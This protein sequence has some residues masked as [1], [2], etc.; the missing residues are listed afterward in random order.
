MGVMRFLLHPTELIADLPEAHRACI[1]GL[2]GRIFPTRV[3]IDGNIM[4]CRRQSSDSGKLHVAW[5]VEGFGRPVITSSS[6]PERDEPYVLA[7]ELARGKIC[8][9]RD[10]IGYW[11]LA[12]M[13]VPDEFLGLHREA[14]RQFARATA[15]QDQPE[16][17]TRLANSALAYAFQ[18]AEIV[19]KSYTNQRL[20]VRR[21][22]TTHLPASLGCNLGHTVP[23]SSWADQFCE[24]FTAA[25]VPL[26]WR[27]IEPK[28]GEY[29]WDVYDQQ[30]EWCQQNNLLVIGG[31]LIDLSPEGI[32]GWLRQWEHDFFNLQSFVCD[33]IETAMS[34]YVGKVRNWEIASRVN[35][36]GYLALNEE[37]RLTLAARTL[38]IASQV[39]DE[40]QLLIGID[41]P[42]GEY[43]ARGNHHL[44]PMQFVDALIRSGA[45]LSGINLEVGVGYR[46]RGSASRDVLDFSRMIDVWSGLGV[47][48]YVKLAF[49]S[50]T[51]ID[52]NAVSDWEVDGHGWKT[53]WSEQAQCDWLDLYLPL[54]MAKQSVVGIQ[55]SHFSDQ[56]PHQYPHA[57]LLDANGRAKPALER[58]ARFRNEYSRDKESEA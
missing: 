43:Q 57:G 48:L 4:T 22:K 34:R 38:E 18:A 6:L 31:P 28:E 46:P 32:P 7:V 45:A 54:L 10:Q 27:L 42:W 39:D 58:I 8:R 49:P 21:R 5:P 44:S 29:Q 15:V 36:G 17:A 20:E 30:V 13:T 2:D 40:N 26:E 51:G 56:T 53:P 19:L 25:V 47:P 16:E 52:E 11:E 9:I 3:E 41:Q 37:N 23:E 35:S 14:H 24:A 12:G 33:F 50:A 1:S 55:W